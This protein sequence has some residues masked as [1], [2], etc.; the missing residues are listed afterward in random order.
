MSKVLVIADHDGVVLKSATLSAVEAAAQIARGDGGE[1]HLLVAG[2]GV[3]AVVR[4][5]LQV[6]VLAKVLHA[7]HAMYEHALA[8]EMANLIVAAAGSYT[9]LV[10]PATSLGKN[11]MP[12]VA[13]LLDVGQIS[14]IVKVVQ[15]DT[16]IRPVCAGALLATVLAHDA[17]KIVTV[18]ASAFAAVATT[19]GNAAVSTVAA[20]A[21]VS[22]S[23]HVATHR[24]VST[25]PELASAR[26]VVA[27]GKG[28]QSKANFKLLEELADV[29]GGAVGASRVAVDLGYASNECQVGQTGQVVAPELYIAVGISGAVQHVAGMKDSKVIV[30]IDKDENAPIFALADYGLV[31]DL[32]EIVPNLT[33][34]LRA[35]RG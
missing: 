34:A 16:F 2:A 8:E 4:H 27:G 25:R 13:A 3:E 22:R 20:A 29:L 24:V 17:I 30:A 14:D 10:A 23:E 1:I 32:F 35:S 31:G 26:V 19:G 9:H 33:Q 11:V 7:D 5:A 15:A 28:L 12:R 21:P 18:R 6:P